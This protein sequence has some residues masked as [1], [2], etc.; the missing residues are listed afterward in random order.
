MCPGSS[1]IVRVMPSF[2]LVLLSIFAEGD[3]GAGV[4][5]G[6]ALFVT[7]QG[8]FQLFVKLRCECHMCW[9]KIHSGA[10]RLPPPPAHTRKDKWAGMMTGWKF[11]FLFFYW[12]GGLGGGGE[13]GATQHSKHAFI[14]LITSIHSINRWFHSLVYWPDHIHSF[15]LMITFFSFIR[16]ITF[17]YSFTWL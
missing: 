12:E 14:H 16:Q 10:Q 17:I 7:Q 9:S 15:I 13:G 8:L 2:W 6:Q 4:H 11:V 5:G 3:E 1:L